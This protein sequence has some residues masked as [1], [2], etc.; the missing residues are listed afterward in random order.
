M[1]GEQSISLPP[2]R[3]SVFVRHQKLIVGVVLLVLAV[4]YLITTSIQNTAVYYFTI[5]E[6]KARQLAPGEMVRVNGLVR[7]GTIE[8]FADGSGA[9]FLMEDA[10]DPSQTM[11]VTYKGLIPD[12]FVDGSEVVVEG[13]LSAAG[14]FDASTL[15]AKCPS[16]FEAET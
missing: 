9:R 3:P 13:K 6:V 12:T 16:K 5:P 1:L 11:A 10:T 15:L 7:A 14:A 4:G 2:S 8:K